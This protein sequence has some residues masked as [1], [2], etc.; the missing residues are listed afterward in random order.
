MAR[1]RDDKEVVG[2]RRAWFSG[3]GVAAATMLMGGVLGMFLVGPC[4][5]KD[6]GIFSKGMVIDRP[7][8]IEGRFTIEDPD[9]AE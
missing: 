2:V 7:D 9:W 1:C 4:T 6:G 5:Y 8:W 3:F